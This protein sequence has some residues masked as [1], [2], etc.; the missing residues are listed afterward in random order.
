M[1][2]SAWQILG[3]PLR[4]DLNVTPLLRCSL[5]LLGRLPQPPWY[6][7]QQQSTTTHYVTIEDLFSSIRLSFWKVD[8]I[9]W[10]RPV[11]CNSQNKDLCGLSNVHCSSNNMPAEAASFQNREYCIGWDGSSWQVK[12]FLKF[13]HNL[14]VE[15]DHGLWNQMAW[16][17][18]PVLLLNS[19]MTLDKLPNFSGPQFH[20][21]VKMGQ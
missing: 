15:T 8:T 7:V 9:N 10:W 16:A 19:C 21:C 1:N 18:I 4:L 14:V 3:Y 6:S 17:W 2:L 12:L 5:R 20:H 13:Q 11:T